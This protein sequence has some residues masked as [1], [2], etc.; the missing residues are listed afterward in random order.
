MSHDEAS[1]EAELKRAVQQVRAGV[2][3]ERRKAWRLAS[4]MMTRQFD[5]PAGETERAQETAV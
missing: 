2:F 5:Q 4:E 1:Y 3:N